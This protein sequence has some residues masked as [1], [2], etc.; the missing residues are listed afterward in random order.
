MALDR[1]L[2]AELPWAINREQA[3]YAQLAFN[4]LLLDIHSVL[5]F[6]WFS[7]KLCSREHPEFR[8]Q[9]VIS[10]EIVAEASR[11]IIL[12]TVHLPIDCSSPVL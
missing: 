7:E 5:T 8:N 1:P 3:I 6:P 2:D 9:M 11:S 10:S 12:S 4:G